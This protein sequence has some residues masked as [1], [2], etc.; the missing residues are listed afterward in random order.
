MKFFT[1]KLRKISHRLTMVYALLF[2]VA[3][4]VVNAATLISLNYYMKQT[5]IQQLELIN[6]TVKQEITSLADIPMVD[7][8]NIS[9]MTDNVDINLTMNNRSVYNTGETYNLP[10]PASN[11]KIVRTTEAGEKTVLYLND[12]IVLMDKTVL[13][14]QIIK[15]MDNE[16]TYLHALSGSMLIID[17]LILLVSLIVGYIISKNAL[18]PINKITQQAQQISA[19]DLSKRIQ[20][21]GPDDELKR[22]A[23]TF[24]DFIIRIQQSYEKQNQFTLDAS[25]EL[26][27]PL[28][29]IKGY[30]D[31]INRW[32]KN[33]PEVLNE[34]LQSIQGE[35]AN[36]TK[37]LDTLLFI[38]KSDHEMLKLEKTKFCLNELLAEIVEESKLVTSERDISFLNGEF[39]LIEA[40]RRLVKQ[41]LRA[42]LDNSI[43]YTSQEGTIVINLEKTKKQ[44][45]ITVKDNGVG[46]PKEDLPHIFDRFYRVD[47]A[48]SR[49]FGGT[50]LG[51]SIVKWIA[52][53]HGGSIT[54]QSEIGHGTTMTIHLPSDV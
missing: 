46:I 54:A 10:F 24:N 48:R 38:G 19:S 21:E 44:A 17:V 3:L 12:K 43:K 11:T 16:Q 4:V 18:N 39:L 45:I 30:V 5:S 6:E 36:M 47:K 7:L 53:I 9:Q 23:D 41:M 49:E 42:V 8:R 34:G 1:F 35:L 25:H 15:D 51:L 31:V 13:G 20:I 52:E 28:A 40:D 27:T 22:L 2:F 14:I 33:D 26:A 37:L 50:G 32:G 29:V